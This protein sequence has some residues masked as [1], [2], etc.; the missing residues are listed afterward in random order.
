MPKMEK[1]FW[2][3]WSQCSQNSHGSQTVHDHVEIYESVDA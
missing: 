2:S 3:E 1:P